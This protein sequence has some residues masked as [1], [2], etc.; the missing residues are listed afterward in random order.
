[1]GMACAADFG[2]DGSTHYLETERVTATAVGHIH[3][4]ALA[5][6]GALYVWGCGSDGRTGLQAYMGGPGG[7]KRRL[8]CYV[9]S[10]SQV[11]SLAGHRV[12]AVACGRYWTLAIVAEE[13]RMQ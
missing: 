7:A 5:A 1:M 13:P 9:S 8:K 11:E 2:K 6:S 4:A 12:L 3:S 10:P